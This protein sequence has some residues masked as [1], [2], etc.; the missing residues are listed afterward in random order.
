[1]SGDH[2]RVLTWNLWWRYGPWE[3]RLPAIVETVRRLDPDLV[4]LQEVWVADGTSSAQIIADTLGFH[5][6]VAHR[7]E[8]D[9]VGFGNAVLSRWPIRRSAVRPLPGGGPDTDEQRLVL[10]AEVE[11]PADPVQVFSAH[12]NWRHD[13]SAIRQAQVRELCA[14]VAAERP[15]HYPPIVCGDFNAEPGSDEVR[16]LTGLAAAP[17]AGIVFRDSW[18]AD[19]TAGPGWTWSNDN[20]HAAAEHEAARRI[21]YVFTGWRRDDGRGV[22]VS[23]RVVGDAPIDGVWPSDHFG[24]LA[25]LRR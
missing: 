25:E 9:G 10:M 12:L 14:F 4:A 20:P 17:E 19:G 11:A 23:S 6:E 16:M 18:T 21:D 5:L 1:M 24:V 13:Q 15:R 3:R 7:L 8:V 2:H 22:P